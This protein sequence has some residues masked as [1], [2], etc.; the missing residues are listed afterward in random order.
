MIIRMRA[1]LVGTEIAFDFDPPP[2]QWR[3][4]S[5]EDMEKGVCKKL[6]AARNCKVMDS[7]NGRLPEDVVT[8]RRIALLVAEV[9]RA[10]IREGRLLADGVEVAEP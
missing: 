9:L 7:S 1:R 5:L 8:P 2:T 4:D 6:E 3:T 10:A